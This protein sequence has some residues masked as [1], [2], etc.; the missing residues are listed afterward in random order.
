M[1]N[2]A[3]PLLCPATAT[4]A[5]VGAPHDNSVW[6]YIRSGGVWTQQGSALVVPNDAVGPSPSAFGWSVA[7]STDGNTAIVG[8]PNDNSAA[9]GAAWVYTRSGGVW[10]EQVK[11]VGTGAVRAGQGISV[12]LSSDG[13]T[14]LVGGNGDNGS[15]GA[16]WVFTRTGGNWTQQGNKLVG[17]GAVGN[18]VQG[19]PSDD[20]TQSGA[21]F[22]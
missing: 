8:G 15:T 5:I 12:A 10:T 3:L 21:D 19:V 11:L 13:N 6:V 4:T 1:P 20:V 22:R 17:A 2:K 18:A 14:A 16:V 9:M 7:L